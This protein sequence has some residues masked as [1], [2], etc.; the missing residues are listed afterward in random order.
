VQAFADA[1]AAEIAAFAGRSV[2]AGR[3]GLTSAAGRRRASACG[4]RGTLEAV[5]GAFRL[6]PGGEVSLE[7]N[8][9][10]VRPET[11]AAWALPDP[12]A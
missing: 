5:R 6:D 7:A 1:L 9:E 8:P 10:D 4:H 3:H 2:R 12:A 11:L